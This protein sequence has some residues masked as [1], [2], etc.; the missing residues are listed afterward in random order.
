MSIDPYKKQESTEDW[1]WFSAVVC[2]PLD[3]AFSNEK[4]RK[5]GA[6]KDGEAMDKGTGSAVKKILKVVERQRQTKIPQCAL[7]SRCILHPPLLCVHSHSQL[8]RDFASAH[9]RLQATSKRPA[10]GM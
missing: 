1:P 4:W 5:V 7:Q 10:S 8:Q 3:K 6:T 2:A 9:T